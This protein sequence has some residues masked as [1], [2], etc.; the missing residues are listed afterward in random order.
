ML[1]TGAVIISLVLSGCFRVPP[2]DITNC[3]PTKHAD[4]YSVSE[5]F[6]QDH[7]DM[8]DRYLLDKKALKHCRERL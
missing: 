2:L 3:D 1:R 4:C 6:L 7:F 5:E 8:Q